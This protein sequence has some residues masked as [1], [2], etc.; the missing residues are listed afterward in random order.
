IPA[1]GWGGGYI[2]APIQNGKAV[3][4][5]PQLID[6]SR[7]YSTDNPDALSIAPYRTLSL[8][9]AL[10]GSN[11]CTLKPG[12]RTNFSG[13]W[14]SILGFLSIV[15]IRFRAKKLGPALLRNRR[16]GD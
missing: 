1:A 16:G 8:P 7:Q 12:E 6:K 5:R 4:M 14:V 15:V 3:Y 13:W 11:S 2:L 10:G 9:E